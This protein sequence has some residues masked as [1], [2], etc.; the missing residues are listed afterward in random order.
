MNWLIKLFSLFLESWYW[1]LGICFSAIIFSGSF[2]YEWVFFTIILFAYLIIKMKDL[3]FNMPIVLITV[4]SL[5][6]GFFLFVSSMT[7][8]TREV[9]IETDKPFYSFSD[10]V[11]ITVNARG[12]ACSHKLIGLGEQ[13]KGVKYYS[14]K[15]LIV[16]NAT[17]IKNNEIAIATV[18]PSA[19]I[20]DFF[21]LY[22]W[23][24]IVGKDYSYIDISPNDMG[25]IKEYC[26]F[27]PKS[28]YVKP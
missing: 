20:C 1:I 27:T 2:K 15:G 23:K 18:S 10:K 25:R 16:L 9:E 8:I 22:P 28:V 4:A 14:D 13:Y 19:E 26:D 7:S 24:R 11:L 5:F 21:W 17:Q 6:Y 12:Y 3:E